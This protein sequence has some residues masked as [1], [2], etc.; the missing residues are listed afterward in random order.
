MIKYSESNENQN[1][2]SEQ[3]DIID[4]RY[5]ND[6]ILRLKG[7]NNNEE[8]IIAKVPSSGSLKETIEKV[9]ARIDKSIPEK[10]QKGA[11]I[12]IPKVKFSINKSYDILLG[13]H[14]ANKGFEDYFFAIAQQ[15]FW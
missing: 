15:G 13:K 2:I 8:I 4:Y 11:S 12:A 10:L 14:L 7:K 3:V 6:F 9:E 5:C 1:K